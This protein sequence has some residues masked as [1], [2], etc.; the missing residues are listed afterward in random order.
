[1]NKKEIKK[2]YNTIVLEGIRF[3]KLI[4]YIETPPNKDPFNRVG[5]WYVFMSL[6]DGEES[7]GYFEEEPKLIFMKDK[8][9]EDEYKELERWWEVFY[10]PYTD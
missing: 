9:T 7:A 2:Y 3:K 4:K 8:L 10:K 5:H 6:T 1:M